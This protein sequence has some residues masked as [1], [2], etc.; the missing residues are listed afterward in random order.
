MIGTRLGGTKPLQ[1]GQGFDPS[2]HPPVRAAR[3]AFQQFGQILPAMQVRQLH[4]AVAQPEQQP[5]G[6]FATGVVIV[7]VVAEVAPGYHGGRHA[8]YVGPNSGKFA[9]SETQV[10]GLTGLH[11]N[12]RFGR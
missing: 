5:Q 10:R 9:A 2:I 12:A 8:L 6:G 3:A 7:A 1:F 11:D 4:H